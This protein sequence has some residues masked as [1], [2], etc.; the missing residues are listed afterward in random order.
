MSGRRSSRLAGS[1]T[2][3]TGKAAT[4]E[5]FEFTGIELDPE[6]ALIAAARI[7]AAKV[8]PAPVIP[9][10]GLFGEEQAA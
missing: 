8:K 2:G 7:E 1:A 6:Y 10:L 4:L 3:S 9:Q 5:G